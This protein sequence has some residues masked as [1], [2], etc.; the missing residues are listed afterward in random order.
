MH[1]AVGSTARDLPLP[2]SSHERSSMKMNLKR[3]EAKWG[4]DGGTAFCALYVV[5]LLVIFAGL[6]SI[7]GAMHTL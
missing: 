1:R 7:A 5:A 4:L 6:M 3:M 2:E